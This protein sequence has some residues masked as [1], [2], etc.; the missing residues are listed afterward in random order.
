MTDQWYHPRWWQRGVQ[1]VA[2]TRPGSWLMVRTLHHMD[3]ALLRLSQ[4]RYTAASTLTGLPVVTLTAVGA[5][6][7]LP[8]SVPLIAIPDGDKIV[9]IGS[10]FGQSHHAAWYYN[11]KAHPQATLTMG[12]QTRPYVAREAEGEEREHYY[13]Q[14]IAMYP[15]YADYRKRAGTRQIPVMVLTPVT[16]AAD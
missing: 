1:Q 3:H 6:S 11:L 4:G 14:A 9:L 8:R 15:G 7:G 12:N 13:R 5:K 16:P 10:N 2:R